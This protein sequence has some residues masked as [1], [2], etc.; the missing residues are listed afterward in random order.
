[1]ESQGQTDNGT[2][3]IVSRDGSIRRALEVPA[4][5]SEDSGRELA[6]IDDIWPVDVTAE[7]RKSLKRSLRNRKYH[8]EEI[9]FADS[10]RHSEF[11]YVAQ[12]PDSIL[13]IVRDLSDQKKAL[14]QVEQ[15][16][17]FDDATDLPNREYLLRE[18]RTII[19]VQNLK[20]GRAAIICVHVGR[21]D[22]QGYVLNSAQQDDLLK[23]LATRL[24][25]H[26]RGPN[27]LDAEQYD[28]FSLVTRTDFRQFTIVLPSIDNGEDAEAVVTRIIEDLTQPVSTGDRMVSV[29]ADAGIALFPQDGATPT[30]LLD[31]AVAAMED[32]RS[33]NNSSLKFHSGTVRLRSLQRQDLEIELRSALERED[34]ALSFLPIVDAMTRRPKTIEALLRWPDTILGT[35]STHKIVRVAERTGLILPIG[36]WVLRHACEQLQAWRQA[37]HDDVR[38]A[39]NLS[40]QEFS[41]DDIVA[42]IS[43]VLEETNTSPGDLE[44][45]LKEQIISREAMKDYTTCR[46]IKALG[47][48]LVIDDYGLGACSLA[49]L[50]RAPVD[51]IKIDNT[52]VAQITN[53]D[54]D[55]AVCRAVI[56]IAEKLGI[57]VTAEGVETEEQAQLLQEYGCQYLQGFLFCQPKTNNEI[58]DYLNAGGGNRSAHW[59]G[60]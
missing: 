41:S 42:S 28:R 30:A 17:Y 45:E 54:N 13:L 38:V 6:S 47:V 49:N 37:G 23:T 11:I 9:D 21:I 2:I 56:A 18:L 15:L 33:C 39:V 20:S 58:L 31:N 60:A 48:R 4:F 52:F 43:S 5:A 40:P 55:R 59:A 51:A 34:Y 27:D 44:I 46:A 1:M 3:L 14:A 50:S 12:G 57:E 22:D 26:V 8:S 24:V 36:K 25:S 19:D 10:E 53:D 35:Q 7:I 32:A 16:A 29:S